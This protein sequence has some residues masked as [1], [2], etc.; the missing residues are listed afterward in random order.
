MELELVLVKF[1]G[2]NTSLSNL[3]FYFWLPRREKCLSHC[4]HLLGVSGPTQILPSCIRQVSFNFCSFMG[5]IICS[6]HKL[7]FFQFRQTGLMHQKVSSL[8]CKSGRIRDS[9]YFF[10]GSHTH[11]DTAVEVVVMEECVSQLTKPTKLNTLALVASSHV[12]IRSLQQM[13]AITAFAQP[14]GRIFVDGG[15]WTR[16][17]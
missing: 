16:N 7:S 4:T 9:S 12:V 15:N 14:N 17:L 5:Y 11:A 3:R 13:D 2:A 10:N 6:I 1:V 8:T